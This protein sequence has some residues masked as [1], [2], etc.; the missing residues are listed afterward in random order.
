MRCKNLQTVF[1]RLVVQGALAHSILAFLKLPFPCDIE[2]T[3]PNPRHNTRIP[4]F[5][6]SSSQIQTDPVFFGNCFAASS[7]SNPIPTQS[8]NVLPLPTLLFTFYFSPSRTLLVAAQELQ[9]T[10]SIEPK[11]CNFPPTSTFGRLCFW[12]CQPP[13]W[14][15]RPAR[16]RTSR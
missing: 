15:R 7:T 6:F 8:P 4:V 9:V 2:S 13:P 16:C 11:L 5:L 12:P 3:S 14:S 1:C 10:F